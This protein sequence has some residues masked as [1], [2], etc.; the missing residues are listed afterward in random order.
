MALY[1]VCISGIIESCKVSSIEIHG[2]DMQIMYLSDV[3][4]HLKFCMMTTSQIKITPY[5]VHC[6]HVVEK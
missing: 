1:I 3:G 4:N 6:W 5:N 2:N